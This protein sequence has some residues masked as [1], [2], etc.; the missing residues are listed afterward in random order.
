MQLFRGQG[1]MKLPFS[2]IHMKMRASATELPP[3]CCAVASMLVFPNPPT[4]RTIQ[5]GCAS[6]P[7]QLPQQLAHAAACV[8]SSLFCCRSCS[9]CNLVQ[10]PAS[11]VCATMLHTAT[12]CF[13]V[14]HATLL[15]G[16]G[17]VDSHSVWKLMLAISL[18]S[19]KCHMPSMN[20]F[21]LSLAL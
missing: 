7:R 3:P 17:P 8:S 6:P 16:D 10:L 14:P 18:R 2:R 1:A 21:S 20:Q 5:G 9:V 4:S 11:S 19:Q 12:L 15:L 13:P